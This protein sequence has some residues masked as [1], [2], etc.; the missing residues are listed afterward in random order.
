MTGFFGSILHACTPK[1]AK[2]AKITYFRRFGGTKNGTSGAQIE[3]LRPLFDRNT[4]LKPL[5]RH[6]WNHFGPPKSD[7]LGKCM[8]FNRNSTYLNVFLF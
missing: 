4:P 8:I 1:M 3:I 7:F 2:T 6:F 5:F